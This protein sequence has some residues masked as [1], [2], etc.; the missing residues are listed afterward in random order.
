[1]VYKRLCGVDLIRGTPL[2]HYKNYL[3]PIIISILLLGL[4]PGLVQG[5]VDA[6][7]SFTTVSRKQE[8][9]QGTKALVATGLATELLKHI[10]QEKRPFSDDHDSFPSG[11]TSLAFAAATVVSD[12]HPKYEVLAYSAASVVGWSRVEDGKH[13]W[14]EVIAGALLGHFVAKQFTSKHIAITPQGIAFGTTW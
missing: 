9:V 8:L 13:R 7:P 10:V 2:F 3:R 12:Y 5:A 11:H 6:P 1:M 14:R 4:F